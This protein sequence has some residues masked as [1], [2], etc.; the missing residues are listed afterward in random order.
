VE[1][2]WLDV[3]VGETSRRYELKSGLTSVGARGDVPIE[4]EGGDQLHFWDQP[5]KLVFVGRGAQPLV[6]GRPCDEADLSPGDAVEWAGA[7]LVY[8]REG[9]AAQLRELDLGALAGA[10]LAP[11][12][13]P[14]VAAQPPAAQVVPLA[15]TGLHPSEEQAWWRLKAGMLVE[16]GLAD[17]GA[18]RRWQDAVVRGEFE[19][20]SCARDLLGTSTLSP[21]DP[22]LAERSAR[23]LRDLLM[24]PVTRGVQGAG[25]RARTAARSGAAFLLAQG[26]VIALYSA[27]LVLALL[28]LRL[29]WGWSVD[30]FL[31]G[32]RGLF[33]GGPA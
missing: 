31:D 21:A 4:A 5:A 16:L 11:A 22:R 25:R 15:P 10:A 9:G 30:G 8:G 20:D 29:R 18:A 28:I 23:L 17:R 6:N 27:L 3:A 1:H 13:A 26:I 14:S 2:S 24:A 7:R 32:I 19:P 12:P 33:G